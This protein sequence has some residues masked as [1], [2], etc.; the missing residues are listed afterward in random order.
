MNFIA[1]LFLFCLPSDHDIHVSVSDITFGY[2]EDQLVAQVRIFLDDL[3]VA[4]GIEDEL[5]DIEDP[6]FK[7][8]V[9]DYLTKTYKLSV[10]NNVLEHRL[11]AIYFEELAL[12]C[13]MIYNIDQ[14]I[15]L[16]KVIKVENQILFGVHSDQINIV[17]CH[18]GKKTAS[19]LLMAGKSSTTIKL[20]Y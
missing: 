17:N 13:A 18:L 1:I 9:D 2:T 10:D 16:P 5:I 14:S 6:Q 7:A 15:E 4:M 12:H 11:E 3:Q 8:A 19:K 20:K